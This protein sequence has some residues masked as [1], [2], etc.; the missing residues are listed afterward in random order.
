MG[1][2][3]KKTGKGRL[4]KYYK[5]AKSVSSAVSA[6]QFPSQV[7]FFSTISLCYSLHVESK[8]IV[9]V[10]RSSSSNSIRNTGFWR[11]PAVR[12]IFAQLLAV[13][14]R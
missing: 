2:A 14:F 13:G 9:L 12:L 10:R 3:Q 4:D 7:L 1:K 5:L 6:I 11:M 8:A